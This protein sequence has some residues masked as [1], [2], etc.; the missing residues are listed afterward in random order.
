MKIRINDLTITNNNKRL[1]IGSIELD[2]SL[3]EMMDDYPKS[4]DQFINDLGA[5]ADKKKAA[6]SQNK[7]PKIG[8]Y[9]D[10]HGGFFAGAYDAPVPGGAGAVA[11]V[12]LVV[13]DG[14]VAYESIHNNQNLPMI[15]QSSING[16]A[17]TDA[18]RLEGLEKSNTLDVLT[19]LIGHKDTMWHI[20]S[21]AEMEH[22]ANNT[23]ELLRRTT[24]WQTSTQAMSPSGHAAFYV[25]D[26]QDRGRIAFSVSESIAC[27]A[28]RWV[29]LQ[30][31]DV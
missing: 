2:I 30:G 19:N 14:V 24:M 9:W 25:Y 16:R 21:S 4:F 26:T 27:L 6:A 10:A 5:V 31:Y 17:N 23:P 7:L 8:E 22:I 1:E 3:Q 18:L 13:L 15:A 29:S 20:P 28:V 11:P 12:G